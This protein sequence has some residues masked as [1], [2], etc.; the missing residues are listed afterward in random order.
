MKAHEALILGSMM[1]RPVPYTRSD[2][3]GGGCALG[4]IGLASG[5]NPH[6]FDAT[7]GWLAESFVEAYPCGADHSYSKDRGWARADRY[8]SAIAHIFN[9]HVCGDHTWTIEK[10]ADWIRENDPT[11]EHEPVAA[12][13]GE[14]EAQLASA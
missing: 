4:M 6:T 3:R 9:E 12:E 14:R 1:M 8:A 10:L 2:G 5:G 11:I 13:A 7:Y